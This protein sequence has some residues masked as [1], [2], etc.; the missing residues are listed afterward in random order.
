MACLTTKSVSGVKCPFF[1]VKGSISFFKIHELSIEKYVEPK[2]S[3]YHS[4]KNRYL[5]YKTL[6]EVFP[7]DGMV[8]K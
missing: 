6:F 4:S 3:G 2:K 1:C 5:T 7:I 8:A